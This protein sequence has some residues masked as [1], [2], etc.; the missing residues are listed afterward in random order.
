MISFSELVLIFYSHLFELSIVFCLFCY[1][2][3][4]SFHFIKPAEDFL[5][6]STDKKDWNWDVGKIC[7]KKFLTGKSRFWLYLEFESFAWKFPS[8]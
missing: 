3:R 8:F 1:S 7:L 2:V 5:F 6:T 4:Y